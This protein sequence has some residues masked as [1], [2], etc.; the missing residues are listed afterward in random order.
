MTEIENNKNPI[1]IHLPSNPSK[2]NFY[3]NNN[4]EEEDKRR[5]Q[6]DRNRKN[7]CKNKLLQLFWFCDCS[8]N[9]TKIQVNKSYSLKKH[10]KI[11]FCIAF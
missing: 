1:G 11:N 2:S 3:Y 9:F 10:Y 5:L 4:K 8:K 6:I 7:I